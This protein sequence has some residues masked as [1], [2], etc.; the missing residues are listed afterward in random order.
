VP[1]LERLS[2]FRDLDLMERRMRRM[3]AEL[4]FPFMPSLAPAA[5]VYETDAEYVVELEVPGY[6]EK[7]LDIE[8]VDHT[9]MVKGMRQEETE[10]TNKRM[11]L[12]ERL[13][14]S[15]ERRFDLPVETDSEHLTAT[16]GNGLLTLHV[17]KTA[18]LA[19]RKI[20]I[21]RG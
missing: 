12:H 6:H 10:K 18:Q 3:F 2:P 5:D 20:E 7:E 15:F 9:L 1:V 4:P 16:Y 19:A 14:S 13:E 17:P 8:V 21:A 11:R